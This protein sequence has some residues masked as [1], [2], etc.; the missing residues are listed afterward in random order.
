MTRQEDNQPDA[1]Q[2]AVIAFLRDPA[3]HG[4]AGP[5]ETITTHA[6]VI[7]LVGDR[8]Y[9]LKRAVT[10]SFLDYGTVQQR[11][12]AC[13][14]EL[15]LNR[16]TAPE[17]YLGVRAIHRL[18]DGGIGWGGAGEILDWVVEMARFPQE[19]L[20]SHLVETGGLSPPL[21]RATADAIAH[22][23]AEA[24]IMPAFGGADGIAAVLA[25]NA[26]NMREM[27]PSAEV[28]RLIDATEAA[29]AAG[30]DLLERR[31]L[32]GR[33]RRCHGDL[34]LRNICLLEGRPVLF[35]CIEFSDQIACT[36]VLY[37][38]AFLLMDLIHR[39]HT[40][41]ASIVF[42]RYLDRTDEEDGLPLLPL[43]LSLRA[44][45]RA[46]VTAR[47]AGAGP[48]PEAAA[49]LRRAVALLQPVPPRLVAIGGL[50]GT[51][52]STVAA[53]LAPL[54]GQA[55]GARLLRSDVL[56]KR[57]FGLAPEE[58]LPPDAYRP[59]VN[60]A[61]YEALMAAARAALAAGVSVILDAV[62]AKPAERAAFATLASACGVP[63]SGLWLEGDP[64]I[65]AAR[66]AARRND[67]SDADDAVLRQQLGYDLG[68]IDWRR[69]DAGG[70]PP[71]VVAAARQALGI[72][73]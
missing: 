29:F 21:L 14:A 71:E 57:H 56:R 1:I 28:E 52:K 27:M 43:F 32:D 16:R 13:R 46:H 12:A 60:A 40:N 38:L 6:S 65:L 73:P 22:F 11:E 61:V 64:A 48:S 31:R 7:F 36:D 33:V 53:A 17:L 68:A 20:F 67:A 25:I 9:K 51:G 24:A 30:H 5:V 45:V 50:S 10:Y 34:H 70:S 49:Y 18:A 19:A 69:I 23:H 72:A 37:D 3:A 44:G 54:I 8:A 63:F 59:E 35:D 66:I 39:G 15:M 47:A 42:N 2:A 58:K 55:P 26:G 41:F 4:G 62:S